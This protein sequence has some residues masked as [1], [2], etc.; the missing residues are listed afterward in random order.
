MLATLRVKNLALAEDLT[1]D[2]EPGFTAITGETGAG[3]SILIGALK[4]A[5]GDRAD[6]GMIRSGAEQCV[7]EAVFEPPPGLADVSRLL[8]GLEIEADPGGQLF[9]KR[10]M[11]ASGAN[12]QLVNGSP[13]ALQILAQLGDILVD[14][15][16]PHDHQSLLHPARQREILDAFG[17]LEGL[18]EEFATLRRRDDQ[19]EAEKAGLRGDNT[20]LDEQ[21]ELLRFQVREIAAARLAPDEE[22]ELEAAHSR[23]ANAAKVLDLAQTALGA[24]AD[25]E[26]S[27]LSQTA[28]ITRTLLE[29]RRLDP[30]TGDLLEAHELAVAALRELQAGL[31]SYRDKIDLNPERLKELEER[32]GLIQSLKRKYGRNIP[33]I[34]SFAATA[35]ASLRALES[36]AA[37]LAGLEVEQESLRDRLA[38]AGRELSRRRAAVIPRLVKAVAAELRDLDLND[39]RF[40]AILSSDLDPVSASRRNFSGLDEVEFLFA[41][42]V[43]EP[44]RPLRTIASSGEMARVMLALKTVLAEQ[45]QVPIL[46][47]DEIDANVGGE[48][49]AKV[50]AKMRQI[51]L[52][53]QVLCITHL[54]PVAAAASRHLVVTKL[55]RDNRTVTEVRAVGGGERVEELARM[56]G[57]RSQA[58]LAHAET[59]LRTTIPC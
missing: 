6:R 14:L 36:R 13:A 22:T 28:Q 12:R 46:V 7:V 43:G 31:G 5:L 3:K 23:A 34:I 56:L 1:I 49:A 27:A 11:T 10:S 39:C 50:G 52:R 59:L 25:D 33:E 47:F 4:L 2:F 58:A 15:H 53:R 51:G 8:A 41:P 30:A 38:D 9:V 35:T 32:L 17:G 54:A 19:I 20:T 24:L 55:S 40:E 26:V 29:L 44:P 57:G 37:T 21:A 48:T 18:R 42:N 16:G 45:D